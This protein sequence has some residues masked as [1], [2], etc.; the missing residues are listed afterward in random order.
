MKTPLVLLLTTGVAAPPVAWF[1]TQQAAGTLTYF[2]C[3][4]AGPPLGLAVG[5]LGI[6][7]CAAAGTLSWRQ[8]AAGAQP[9]AAFAGRVGL[10]LAAIFALTNLVTVAA[11]CL[12][13]PCA[14]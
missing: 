7:A 1:V 13:P 12:I 2:A 6:V 14:R 3:E 9:G 10:G 11:I 8:V 4:T 5:L